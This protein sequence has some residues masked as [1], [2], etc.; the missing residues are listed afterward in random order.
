MFEWPN[1]GICQSFFSLQSQSPLISNKYLWQ[2]IAKK[3][4]YQNILWKESL[5]QWWLTIQLIPGLKIAI[6][7]ILKNSDNYLN[8]LFINI[9]ITDLNPC[10]KPCDPC[11]V[12]IWNT[13]SKI[14]NLHH[15]KRTGFKSLTI[16]TSYV[17]KTDNTYLQ[18]HI[19]TIK[20]YV[21]YL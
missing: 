7:E 3:K 14:H 13:I 10:V 19:S 11:M 4:S 21:K 2:S 12:H 9:F 8:F 17:S 20:C 16:S 1:F 15:T 6:E 5:K 18:S